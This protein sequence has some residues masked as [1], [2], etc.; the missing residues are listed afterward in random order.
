MKTSFK[1]TRGF[2]NCN[3][4]NIRNSNSFKWDG[5]IGRDSDNFCVFKSMLYGVR[6]AFG[7]LRSYNHR[8]KIDTIRGIITRWAP[9]SENDTESYIQHVAAAAGITPDERIHYRSPQMRLVVKEMARIESN[10]TLEDSTIHAAQ[11]MI[12]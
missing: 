8:H 9:P 7:L 4:L 6:A 3:P 12:L 2:R 10:V 1:P 5:Q 11:S